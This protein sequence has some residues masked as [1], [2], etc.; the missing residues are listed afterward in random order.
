MLNGYWETVPSSIKHVLSWETL[1]LPIW[2]KSHGHT[3]LEKYSILICLRK[4]KQKPCTDFFFSVH[5]FYKHFLHMGSLR[6]PSLSFSLCVSPGVSSILFS[7]GLEKEA[8]FQHVT[9]KQRWKK[10]IRSATKLQTSAMKSK[11]E[12]EGKW[13]KKSF[14]VVIFTPSL[15]HV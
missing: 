3:N 8:G 9:R 6:V 13:G 4:T 5:Q 10:G 14:P 7:E 15:V 2:R 1:P 12:E 11:K